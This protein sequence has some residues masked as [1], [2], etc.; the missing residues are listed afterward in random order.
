MQERHVAAP[1]AFSGVFFQARKNEIAG[2][3]WFM[4]TCV[5]AW[6]PGQDH[7]TQVPTCCA[8]RCLGVL[9]SGGEWFPSAMVASQRARAVPC[10]C[11]FHGLSVSRS[12]TPQAGHADLGWVNHATAVGEPVSG[13]HCPLDS[14]EDM[15]P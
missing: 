10:R 1:Q 2:P 14:R 11:C 7:G 15:R 12:G 8:Q 4:D 13:R 6:E 5:K 9:S 3:E